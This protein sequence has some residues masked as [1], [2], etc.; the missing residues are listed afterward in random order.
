MTSHD[1][2]LSQHDFTLSQHDTSHCLNMTLSQHNITLS[3]H[4]I[5]CFRPLRKHKQGLVDMDHTDYTV[6]FPGSILA[7]FQKVI[8]I[9]FRAN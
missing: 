4:D 7:M 5:T 9:V 2:T 6:D 8:Q 1:I 3:Q